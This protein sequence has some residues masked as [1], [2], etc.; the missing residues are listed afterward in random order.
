MRAGERPP[1]GTV[2]DKTLETLPGDVG[3][4]GALVLQR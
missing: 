2:L 1:P 3:T 4:I